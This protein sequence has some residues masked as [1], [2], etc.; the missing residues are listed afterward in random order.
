MASRLETKLSYPVD[1]HKRMVELEV[2]KHAEKTWMDGPGEE[3]YKKFHFTEVDFVS[4]F[5][6]N[7]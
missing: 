5:L 7:L 1:L 4:R 2:G 6:D 3:R